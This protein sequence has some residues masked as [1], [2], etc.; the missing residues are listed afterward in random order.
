[1]TELAVVILN[2]NGR[3]FL[4]KFLPSVIWNSAGATIVVVDNGSTDDSLQMLEEKFSDKIEIIKIDRNLGFCGGYNYALK[5]IDAEYYVLLNSDVEVTPNWIDPV[6]KLFKSNNHIA[7]IQPKVKSFYEKSKFEYAG[8]AGG[9]ID[10]LGFPFCRGR[11]FN[12]M[13]EDNEQYN[14]SR[15]IFWATGAC[16]F[17]RSEAYHTMGG[18]DEDFFA[19]MEEIDLC[20]R[21]NR[22]GYQVFYCGESTIYHVGGGTLSKSNPRKTQLNFRNGLSMLLKHLPNHSVWWK[23]PVRIIL[24]WFAAMLF[25]VRGSIPDAVAVLKAHAEFFNRFHKDLGKRRAFRLLIPNYKVTQ[26]YNKM[27]PVQHFL[28]GKKIVKDLEGFQ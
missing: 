9:F 3:E 13:E 10:K 11:I 28:L 1:M 27:L 12:E 17:I 2:Y 4:S 14:D 21:L 20:W 19:H 16:L 15:Q 6:L 8:A 5:R 22:A 7:A 23:I 26:V 24:D 25:L 18:L